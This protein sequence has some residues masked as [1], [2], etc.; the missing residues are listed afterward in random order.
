MRFNAETA[1]LDDPFQSSIRG[2]TP[3]REAT[4]SGSLPRD[5]IVTV[6]PGR[7][8]LSRQKLAY[9]VGISGTT[10]GARGISMNL[11]VIPPGAAAEPHFHEGFETAIYV[12]QGR[13]LTRFGEG[14]AETTINE[15]GDFIFIPASLPHQPFNLSKTVSAV[16]IVA[17]NDA[18]EQESVVPYDPKA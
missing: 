7:Q 11:V 10:A 8:I 13:V 9:F 17:R 4:M 2:A 16:A 5:A 12:L 14:L 3:L 18:N 6:R 15:A 1:R